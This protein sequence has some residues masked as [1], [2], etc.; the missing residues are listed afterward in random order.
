MRKESAWRIRGVHTILRAQEPAG[1][2][3]VVMLY[4]SF[5]SG[6]MKKDIFLDEMWKHV[7]FC[8]LISESNKKT[9]GLTIAHIMLIIVLWG[10]LVPKHLLFPQSI[11]CLLNNKKKKEGKGG[12]DHF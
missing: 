5:R 8:F 12:R 6:A 2:E 11:L 9:N 1:S 4:Q 7:E 10:E 3:L